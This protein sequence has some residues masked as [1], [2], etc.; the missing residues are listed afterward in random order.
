[1]PY[2]NPAVD[3]DRRAERYAD[4]AAGGIC[5]RCPA[6][7][8]KGKTMC[9]ACATKSGDRGTKRLAERKAAGLCRSCPAP[10]RTGKARC[11]KCAAKHNSSVAECRLKLRTAAVADMYEKQGGGCA[12]CHLRLPPRMLTI[13]HIVP[14]SKGGG[15]DSSNLQLLCHYCNSVKR[16]RTQARLLARLREL[17]VI[18]AAGNNIEVGYAG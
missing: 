9:A 11:A 12:A 7:A 15:D 16:T 18:D 3:R 4:R 6:P 10:A 2:A 1:M 8:R 17:G 14:K 5:T 13:D